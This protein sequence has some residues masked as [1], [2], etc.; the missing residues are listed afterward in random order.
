[1]VIWLG[2]FGGLSEVHRCLS[3]FPAHLSICE[4]SV[5]A[6]LS[7]P[8]QTRAASNIPHSHKPAFSKS[9]P[10]RSRT[11]CLLCEVCW[12]TAGTYSTLEAHDWAALEKDTHRLP[13]VAATVWHTCSLWCDR[14]WP[15]VFMTAYEL[16]ILCIF[17]CTCFIL[18]KPRHSSLGLNKQLSLS[19]YHTALPDFYL[20]SK[21]PCCWMYLLYLVLFWCTYFESYA[22]SC[23][24]YLIPYNFSAIDFF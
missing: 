7:C 15:C 9:S 23:L 13:T 1:M 22:T 2:G 11:L 19:F 4:D 24:V 8:G 14:L 20:H 5:R 21:W 18:W 10:S 17:S 12:E 3:C 6:A 16:R